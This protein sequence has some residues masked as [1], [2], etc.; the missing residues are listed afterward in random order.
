M[1]KKTVN[2]VTESS[3]TEL[4]TAGRE[5]EIARLLGSSEITEAALANAWELLGNQARETANTTLEE[6]LQGD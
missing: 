4:D 6:L 2:D 3:V 1:K 5:Q